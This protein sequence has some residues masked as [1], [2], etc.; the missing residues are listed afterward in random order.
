MRT[1][2]AILIASALACS[3]AHTPLATAPDVKLPFR[4]VTL[5]NGLTAVLQPDPSMPQVGVEVWIRGGSRE[6]GPR[7]FG[8]AH[9]FEHDVP[10]SGR[11]A[12]NTENRARFSA[13]MRGSGAG[14]QFDY[15]RFYNQVA[16]EGLEA[17]LAALADRLE[18]DPARF[19]EKNLARDQD[20]VVSELRRNANS[21]WDADI[22][23]L[24][25][26]G[27]F[28]A[29]HPYG[30]STS[31]NEADV[32]AATVETMREW[33]RRFA[34]ASNAIVFVVGN[35]DPSRAEQLVRH[36]Y[37]SIAPGARVLT[38]TEPPPSPHARR[39]ALEKAVPKPIV[40]LRW[41]VAAWGTE[42][43][44]LLTLIARI[45]SDRLEQNDARAEVNLAELAGSFT[46][47]GSD[48]S[49]LRSALDA[50]LH[51][52]P[53]DAELARAKARSQTEFV[54]ALQRPV[55]RG[56]RADVLGFGLMFHGDANHYQKQLARIA[57]ATRDEVRDAARRWLAAPPYVLDV[58][59]QPQRS[60]SAPV[61][62]S[63]T[64]AP[65]T[66]QPIAFP[67]I[68][69]TTTAEGLRV[70]TATRDALP[71]AQLTF[72]FDA[73]ADVESLHPAIADFGAQA[74]I[75]RDADF[76]ALHVT[77]LSSHANDVI[78]A[79]ASAMTHAT[80]SAAKPES[81]PRE[82]ALEYVIASCNDAPRVPANAARAFLA[83][84]DVAHIDVSP[85]RAANESQ[86][87]SA[88]RAPDRE[89]FQ[90]IDDPTATQARILLA[91]VLP[92]GV[93]KDPLMA[94]LVASHLLRSRLMD[95]LRSSKGWTYEVYPFRLALRR[96]GAVARFN[97]PV[98][99]DKT[100][101]SIAEVRKEIE[102][103]REEPIA[104]EDL[105]R[106]RAF[107]ESSLTG[108][109]MSLAALNEQLL[110]VA[111]NDLPPA[112]FASAVQRLGNITPNEAQNAARE[113]LHADR[114]IWIIAGPRAAIESELRE[115]GVEVHSTQ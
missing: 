52:A 85:L 32:R 20:I 75:S 10:S 16:P 7:E 95:N 67:T 19:T 51:G 81:D 94:Q 101:E 33:H 70:L 86:T 41:P 38:P 48:E 80:T 114:L 93:S 60:A 90:I 56:S 89:T 1:L 47:R 91:Q 25:Q 69:S 22:T 108:G 2:A 100:A 109:L 37:G 42:D 112:Y 77:V 64:I 79:V 107:L 8:V 46:L 21:E 49:T 68:R 110:D 43:G 44:D 9:L 28:G 27:T 3:H 30:H 55:W 29:S 66:P 87:T 72:A 78:R 97:I 92:S 76:A 74:E 103:L 113:L 88:L 83:S 96:G 53:N 58:M 36:Y 15:L 12:G 39:D 71:L 4:L 111:R 105:A 35:F 18:S 65:V 59:S 45:L 115:L 82:H 24:L 106:S 6:E 50:L 11:F 62:R 84:G 34:G 31:G 104:P 17:A 98:Q 13:A 14:T 23:A 57:A 5:D 40:Y 99:L 26:R 54:D 61:D 102:R 63:A 73:N